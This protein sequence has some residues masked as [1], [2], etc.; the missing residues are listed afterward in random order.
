[1]KLVFFVYR[2]YNQHMK[3]IIIIGGLLISTVAIANTINQRVETVE[4]FG[5]F[6]SQN[7]L[8]TYKFK[9]G[10]ITCYGQ[11]AKHNNIVV[12]QSISCVK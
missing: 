11:V 4:L 9:D 8:S 3:T 1:V 6:Q 7:Q 10:N 5:A 12:S 2:I